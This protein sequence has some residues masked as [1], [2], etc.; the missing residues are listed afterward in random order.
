MSLITPAKVVL[1]AFTRIMVPQ[2]RTI[3]H[4]VASRETPEEY[5]CK[6]VCFF[7]RHDIDG[8]DIRQA[9]NDLA[10]YDAVPDPKII[11]AALMACRRVND[12]ALTVRFLEM[13]KDKCGDKITQFYPYICQEVGPVVLELGCDFPED[14]GYDKPELWLKSVDDI[15]SKDDD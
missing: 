4:S 15:H 14:L 13:V 12:Y 2:L 6:Y 9:M 10:G 8:W 1:N 5:I 7:N 3:Y 11:I